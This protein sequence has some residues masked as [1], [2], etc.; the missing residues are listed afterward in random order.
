MESVN[1]E[2]QVGPRRSPLLGGANLLSRVVVGA[3]LI[4]AA[5]PAFADRQHLVAILKAYRFF[6]YG[7]VESLAAILPFVE[8]AVGML[9]IVG[10]FTRVSAIWASAM[11]GSFLIGLGEA[12]LR[13]LHID[14]GCS[15]VPNGRSLISAADILI[16]TV[17]LAMAIFVALHPGGPLGLDRFRHQE[18]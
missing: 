17:F 18:E 14:C 5:L 15:L 12:A 8:V 7:L 11:L 16:V 10:L 4:H 6:P 13:G 1:T 9:L 2:P 3:A